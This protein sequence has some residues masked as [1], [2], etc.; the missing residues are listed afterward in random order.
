MQFKDRIVYTSDPQVVA[1]I[2]R[3]GFGDP[4]PVKFTGTGYWVYAWSME[5]YKELRDEQGDEAG[6]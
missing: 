5:Q 4:I 6:T 3:N 1:D 2:E